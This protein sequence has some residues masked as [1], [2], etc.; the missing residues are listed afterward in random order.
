M[1]QSCWGNGPTFLT[2]VRLGRMG[3][4]VC[5]GGL[6]EVGLFGIVPGG[7]RTRIDGFAVG[8][9]AHNVMPAMGSEG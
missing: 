4:L 7:C 3:R 2:I 1:V 8:H 9:A 6:I 5:S